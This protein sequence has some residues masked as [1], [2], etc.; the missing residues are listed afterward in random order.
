MI[1]ENKDFPCFFQRNAVYHKGIPGDLLSRP[2]IW[3][4]FYVAGDIVM[5]WCQVF[6]L[7]WT[8]QF[9]LIFSILKTFIKRPLGYETMP[10][11]YDCPKKKKLAKLPWFHKGIVKWYY[12]SEWK[13][14]LTSAFHLQPKGERLDVFGRD[15]KK[16]KKRFVSIF[17]DFTDRIP[18]AGVWKQ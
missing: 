11:L 5:I 15:R 2:N 14:P 6:H 16:K 18:V 3:I 1:F 4:H 9:N 13:C 10:V 12:I 8:T 7:T 17:W